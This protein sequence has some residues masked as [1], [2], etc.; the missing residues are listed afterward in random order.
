MKRPILNEA[1]QRYGRWTILH[2]VYPYPDKSRRQPTFLCRCDCGNL[3]QI[4][5]QSLRVGDSRSC[6]CLMLDNLR[7][8]GLTGHPLFDIWYGMN[9]RCY[10][11]NDQAYERYGGRGIIVCDEWRGDAG[12]LRFITDMGYRPDDYSL[13]RIDNN[14]P[15]SKGNCRWATP[16]QQAMNRRNTHVISHGGRTGSPRDWAEWT[17]L[18][19]TTIM[20]RLATGQ[21]LASVL[22]PVSRRGRRRLS[23]RAGT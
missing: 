11:P 16:K 1:G 5:G 17:G 3:R 10:D 7:T 4:V 12:V 20:R 9:R 19:R 21:T 6:G 18:G 15:Y 2:R 23:D 8:H 13:D 14:G 22:D